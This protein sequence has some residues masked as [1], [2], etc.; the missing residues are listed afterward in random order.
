V[1]KVKREDFLHKLEEVQPGLS[2]R[3]IVQQ[4]NCFGF[5]NGE[6]ITFNED[7]ACRVKSG[8]GKE[9]KGAVQAGPLVEM[10]KAYPDEEIEVLVKKG[11]FL[12]KG[13]GKVTKFRMEAEVLMPMEAVEKPGS[14][15]PIHKDFTDAI[16]IVE[17]CASSDRTRFDWTCIHITPKFM[18]ACDD[19]QL[20]RYNLKTGVEKPTLVKRD[21]LRHIPGLG[22]TEISET[23]GWLHFRNAE[24][25]VMSCQKEEGQYDDLSE[26]FK[27]DG[28][29]VVLPKALGETVARAEVM[30][31]ENANK[32][33]ILV[34]TH[35]G[36]MRVRGEG[37]IGEHIEMRKIKYDG[38]D[39]AFAVSPKLLIELVDKYTDARLSPSR[40]L[41]V[42]GGKWTYM[43]CLLT[44]PTPDGGNG[45]P[46]KKEKEG[47]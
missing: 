17:S 9:L 35:G 37:S 12:I 6:V 41:K 25:L 24:G 4:S 2:A 1:P 27:I 46:K 44:P 39:M 22:M 28:Q 14:W 29:K 23:A 40:K 33:L 34:E 19:H 5:L 21:S 43:A 13:K 10:L 26:H 42:D 47:E 20:A 11:V 7:V 38:P 8:V 15:N 3:A 32:N 36:Q 30:S 45:K 16:G 31:K 18:E